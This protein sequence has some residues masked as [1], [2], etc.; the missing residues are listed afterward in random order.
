MVE[1]F[2]D[3]TR[4]SSPSSIVPFSSGVAF[5]VSVAVCVGQQLKNCVLYRLQPLKWNGERRYAYAITLVSCFGF[6]SFLPPDT[7]AR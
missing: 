3:A 4:K 7:K 2:G 5:A 1:M 6:T